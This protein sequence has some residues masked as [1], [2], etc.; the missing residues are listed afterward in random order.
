MGDRGIPKTWR[1]MNGYSSHTYMWVNK[2]GERFWVKYHFKT[3]QGIE[4]LTQEKADRLAGQDGDY[5]K[6]DLFEAIGRG[7]FPSWSLRVQVMPFGR[8]IPTASIH[9]ISRRCGPSPTTRSTTLAG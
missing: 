9:L 6:R 8:P 3:D 5:H 1:N 4:F 7:D 2:A